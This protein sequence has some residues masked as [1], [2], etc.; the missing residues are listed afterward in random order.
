MT[1]ETG[2]RPTKGVTTD[3]AAAALDAL[4]YELNWIQQRL[5]PDPDGDWDS[6][7]D[8]DRAFFRECIEW[9]LAHP[10]LLA[11]AMGGVISPTI[12]S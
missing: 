6:Y 2:R 12:T 8:R 5:D 11:R 7:S 10:D 4:A 9:L 1:D 3:G